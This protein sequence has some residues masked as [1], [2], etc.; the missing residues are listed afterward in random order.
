M[1]DPL[2]D[3]PRKAVPPPPPDD[4]AVNLLDGSIE[5]TDDSPT[6]ISRTPQPRLPP[7]S[8]ENFSGSLRGRRL[9]HFE[10]IE[11]I[12]VGGMAAVL[13]ARDTQLDRQVALKILPPEMAADPEN[14]RRFHQEARSAARLDHENIARVF[15]CGEDQRLHFI[16]FEFVE[17][18]NLRVLLERR[19]RLPVS[20]ALNYMLQV[21]AGL[22]HAAG[23]G[24]VHRDIKPSN[25]IIT[26]N[27]RAKLVDM[28]LA[29]S[30]G[31]QQDMGLTQ[32]GVTLGTFDYISPEQAL[33][34]RD[35]D[36]RSDIYSLGCTFY[37]MLTG[38]PPVPEGTAAKKLHHHQHVKPPDPRQFVPDLPDEAAVILDRMIAKQ[39]RDRYQTPEQLVHH[40]YLAARKLGAS[41]EAPEGVLAVEAALPNPPAGRPLV[42]AALAAVAVVGLIFLIDALSASKPEPSPNPAVQTPSNHKANDNTSGSPVA[43]APTPLLKDFTSTP[44]STPPRPETSTPVYRSDKPTA[45]EL[46]KFLQMHKQDRE[47]RIELADDLI[48]LGRDDGEPE[49]IVTNPIVTIR[50]RDAHKRPT[51]IRYGYHARTSPALQAALTIDSKDCTVENLR[52]VLDQNGA[53]VSMAALHLRGTRLAKVHGCEFLQADPARSDKNRLA[54]VFI[55]AREFATLT[56]SESC[57]LGFASLAT[58][59]SGPAEVVFSGAASGGQDAVRR[60]GPVRLEA[61]NCVFG[62][63]AAT[64][65]LEGHA[66]DN[67]GAVVLHHCSILTANQSA[68][69]DV[70]DGADARI[71]ANASLFSHPGEPGMAGMPEDKGAVLVRQTSAPGRVS[72]KGRDNRYH[73]LDRYVAGAAEETRQSLLDQIQSDDELREL[74]TSP[75]KDPQPLK[76]L[77]QLA[78]QAAF[79]VNPLLPEL[80][81]SVKDKSN[82]RLVG[83]EQVLAFSYLDNLPP[84]KDGPTPSERRPLVVEREKSDRENHLY[85]TLG[86]ALLDAQPGD[87]IRL[88][89]DGDVKLDPLALDGSRLTDLTIAAD[90]GFHPVLTLGDTQEAEAALFRVYNGKLRLEGLQLRLQ[91]ARDDFDAQAVVSF[92]GDGECVLSGCVITLDRSGKKAVL[93]VAVLNEPGKL[94]KKSDTPAEQKPR[95][96][97]ENSFVRGQGDLVLVAG[98]PTRRSYHSQQ[99]DRPDRLAAPRR[100]QQGHAGAGGPPLPPAQ[101]GHDVPGR[102]PH[103]RAGRQ[104]PQ[105]LGAGSVP[106]RGLSV[107]ARLRRRRADPS[108]SAGGRG[109]RPDGQTRLERRDQRLRRL[110]YAGR[111]AIDRRHDEDAAAVQ[112]E[113]VEGLQPRDGQPVQRQAAQPARHRYAHRATAADDVPAYREGER[114]WRRCRRSPR[115]LLAARERRYNHSQIG[116]FDPGFQLTPRRDSN[117]RPP[118]HS[119]QKI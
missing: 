108:R 90:K 34:P 83:A 118:D 74:E 107:S 10:L 92:L 76:Q 100:G 15:F 78:I 73:Q 71:E 33:E 21:A 52:F 7:K 43:T 58:A 18:D 44:P 22:A 51:T 1:S 117:R 88:R 85:P 39:P 60:R 112:S 102:E 91:P 82:G 62:P 119:V 35:A 111:T 23:R 72:Y 12:G 67:E 68:V 20:E 11:P 29:R 81:L 77:E 54:S 64:F 98:R 37:H 84:L 75:W 19:G 30:L 61:S 109:T 36:V 8:D 28:G 86:H 66:P 17:G 87:V 106:A 97:L 95:L 16:A 116:K 26:P 3:P 42:L 105:E 103:P 38:Q 49:L 2:G 57:F 40:L 110:Q 115:P 24:V 46:A 101:E 96:V 113:G 70:A 114:L 56:L 50:A 99:P 104:G 48:L 6:V 31:P 53:G 63:H 13:R 55:E 25:I 4:E 65:R 27:G 89:L 32:S 80:R 93:A 79:Q 69:F 47:I 5:P 14:V 45:T 94:M 9:A 59:D 41:A